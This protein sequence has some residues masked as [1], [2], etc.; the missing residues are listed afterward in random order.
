MHTLSGEYLTLVTTFAPLLSRRIWRQ[1]QVLLMGVVLA[2]SE[3][4]HQIRGR[5]HKKL[6]GWGRQLLLQVRR[7]L[8]KRQLVVVADSTLAVLDL[9]WR[10][11]QV[12]N[13][14]CMVARFRLDAALYGPAPPRKPGQRG[15]KRV[16][17]VRLP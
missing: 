13:P 4:Y 1:V 14:I 10:M 6:T 15:R 17:G 7:W 12:A 8:P 16:K 9:L 5:R 2:P 11:T 3:R